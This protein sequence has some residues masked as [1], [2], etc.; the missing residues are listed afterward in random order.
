MRASA[1]ELRLVPRSEPLEALRV[2]Q[3]D[4]GVRAAGI[5]VS[6]LPTRERE[7]AA[8]HRAVVQLRI[9]EIFEGHE[10]EGT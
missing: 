2:C 1:I 3:E 9:G 10:S 6:V 7:R 8:R 4:P 5:R